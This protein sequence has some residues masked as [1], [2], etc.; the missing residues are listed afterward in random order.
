MPATT[1]ATTAKGKRATRAST[2]ASGAKTRNARDQGYDEL[3]SE[4]EEAGSGHES[5]ESEYGGLWSFD[6]DFVLLE[7]SSLS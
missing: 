4:S 2:C 6:C 1:R 3:L 5:D 7:P